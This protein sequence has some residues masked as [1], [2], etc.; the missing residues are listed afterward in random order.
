M[1]SGSH[2]TEE[3]RTSVNEALAQQYDFIPMPFLKLK[4]FLFLCNFIS[5]TGA[6]ILLRY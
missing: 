3:Q 5:M 1:D 4:K 2:L 6:W